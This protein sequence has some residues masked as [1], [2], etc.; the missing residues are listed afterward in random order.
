MTDRT[1]TISTATQN[2]ERTERFFHDVTELGG[3]VTLEIGLESD[4]V[5]QAARYIR[6]RAE[7][8]LMGL[9]EFGTDL[10]DTVFPR[11]DSHLAP[12]RRDIMDQAQNLL[13]R[14][15]ANGGTIPITA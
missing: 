12:G 9:D 10:R 3:R 6:A 5:H 1:P 13:N 14:I 2:R 7:R 8:A 11:D 4:G 15:D